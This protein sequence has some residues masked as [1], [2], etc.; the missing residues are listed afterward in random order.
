MYYKNIQLMYIYFIGLSLKKLTS[1]K[2]IK[3]IIRPT[4]AI[5]C[6][7]MHNSALLSAIFLV[8][9]FD[10]NMLAL[11]FVYAKKLSALISLVHQK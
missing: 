1:F 5:S 8:L 3:K 2:T 6:G 9:L 11:I 4:T 10:F 7:M